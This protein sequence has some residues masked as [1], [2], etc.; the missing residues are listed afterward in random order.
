METVARSTDIR[1]CEARERQDAVLERMTA[2]IDRYS[3]VV[4]G[5]VFRP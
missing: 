3:E 5:H 4:A 1:L 2:A